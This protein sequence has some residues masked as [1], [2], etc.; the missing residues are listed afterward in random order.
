MNQLLTQA[1]HLLEQREAFLRWAQTSRTVYWNRK[2]FARKWSNAVVNTAMLGLGAGGL[3]LMLGNVS[4]ALLGVPNIFTIILTGAV[5]C[6]S[7]SAAMSGFCESQTWC[8]LALNVFIN[9]KSKKFGVQFQDGPQESWNILSKED[10]IHLLKHIAEL[11]GEWKDVAAQLLSL[12]NSE[13]IPYAWWVQMDRIVCAQLEHKH[14]RDHDMKQELQFSQ[15]QSRIQNVSAESVEVQ[16]DGMEIKSAH[17]VH[18]R[19]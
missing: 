11:D 8:S 3:V 7:F 14:Q 5:C 10:K 9:K 18:I 6:A 13:N 17:N 4:G 2:L 16:T 19:L 12:I 1:T 15:L